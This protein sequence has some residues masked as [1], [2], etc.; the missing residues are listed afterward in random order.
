MKSFC[1]S[2]FGPLPKKEEKNDIFI[3]P[4]HLQQNSLTSP[5]F[6]DSGIMNST[7]LSKSDPQPEAT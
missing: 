2:H 5:L 6:P 1:S 4:E 7:V 3:P